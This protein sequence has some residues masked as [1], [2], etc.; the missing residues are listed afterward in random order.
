VV[1]VV[2][3]IFFAALFFGKR[4]VY[5]ADIFISTDLCKNIITFFGSTDLVS[6]YL[7]LS[8]ANL[9]IFLQK[10][11]GMAQIISNASGFHANA[12]IDYATGID[13]DGFN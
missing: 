10:N 9:S 8:L 7:D 5:R 1:H 4:R 12:G 6:N 2:T 11:G 13:G 3:K